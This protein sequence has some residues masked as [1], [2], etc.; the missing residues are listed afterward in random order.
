MYQN[1]GFLGLIDELPTLATFN[2]VSLCFIV[3]FAILLDLV[4]SAL[5]LT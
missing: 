4:F 1:L 3:D 5:N 2:I